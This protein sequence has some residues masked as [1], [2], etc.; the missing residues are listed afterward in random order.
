MNLHE[1]HL[2]RAATV[3]RA[4][5]ALW[6][7]PA[8]L[9]MILGCHLSTEGKGDTQISFTRIYDSLKQYDDVVIVLKNLNGDTLDVIFRGKVENLGDVQ[10][11]SAPHWDGGKVI[12]SI[13]GTKDGQIVYNVETRFDPATGVKDS[14]VVFAPVIENLSSTVNGLTLYVGESMLLPSIT[15]SQNIND[16][17]LEWTSSPLGLLNLDP[18]SIN[19]LQVGKGE[20]EVHLKSN[21]SVSLSI[22]VEVLAISVMPESISVQPESL[23]VAAGGTA[24]TLIAQVFPAGSPSG[25]NWSSEDTGI[26]KVDIAGRVQGVRNGDARV[27]AASRVRPNLHGAARIK[28]SSS[29][30]V[31]TLAFAKDSLDILAGGAAESLLVSVLPA[32]ADP[33]VTFTVSDPAKASVQNAKVTGIAAGRVSVIAA[34]VSNPAAKDTLLV[35]I[36]VPTPNDTTPPLKPIVHVTPVGPTQNL[37][38][39]W[40]W[41]SG[42]GGG[43]GSYQTSL[44]KT[45]FDATTP[46]VTDTTF[47]PAANLA[48]GSH[49]LYVRERDAAGNWSLPGSAQVVLDTT[50]PAAPK[51]VGT[52]PTS[53]LPRWT[54]S[55]GGGGGAGVYRSWLVDAS[56]PANAPE[57][58]DSA[59]ALTTATTGTTYTLFVEERD[60]AGNWSPPARLAIKYDLTKPTVTIALPQA[61][62]TFITASA[63]VAVSG[64]ATGPNTITKIEYTLDAGTPSAATLGTGGSWSIASLALANGQTTTIT[65]TATD[66][67]GN[68]GQAQLKVLRDSDVPLPPTAL[69]KPTSPTNVALSSWSWAAGGDGATGSGLNGNYQWKLN[70]GAWTA[71]TTA[72]A[73][74]VTLAEGSNTFSVEEQDKAGNWSDVLTGTVVLDTKA[75]DAVTFVGIDGTLTADDTPTWSW[76][77][78]TTNG[79]I[80]QYILKLD[81]GAEF[82]GS[83]ATSYIPVTSLSDNT[84]HTLTV[85]EKDQ[86]PGVVGAAKSFSYKIKVNPPAAPTVKSAVAGLTSGAFT[87]NPGF[88]WTSGGGGNGKFR[89]KVNTETSYRVN[90]VAQTTFSL[91]NTDADGTYTVS[92]SEQDDLGR[93]SPDGTFIIQLDRTGPIYSEVYFKGTTMPVRD[94]YV[95]NLDTVTITYKADGAE[96]ELGCKLDVSGT[97]KPCKA[98]NTDGLGNSSTIQRNVYCRKNVVFFKPVATGAMDG[99][100]WENASS[101][102]KAYMDLP[103][104]KGKD[105]WLASGDYSNQDIQISFK[106][107]NIYGGFSAADFP[108]DSNNRVKT[109][110]Y[111]GSVNIFSYTTDPV[112]TYD[113]LRF[114]KGLVVAG[115]PNNFTD[116]QSLGSF[117]ISESAIVTVTNFELNGAGLGDSYLFTGS[118]TKLTWDGGKINNNVPKDSTGFAIT[119]DLGSTLILKGAL[120]VS[121]NENSKNYG[122]QILNNGTLTIDS[123]VSFNCNDLLNKGTATCRGNQ[124]P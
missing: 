111:L 21:H 14:I 62:G 12:V 44:D 80:G 35:K 94:G 69:V 31:E 10:K 20:I 5:R 42:G 15:M 6:L 78:S 75:P 82:D 16:T 120:T 32:G 118:G 101:D 51:L 17:T 66:N 123:S 40:S 85:K 103:D 63:T 91:S 30:L 115:S 27:W 23:E 88:I 90:G 106:W 7:L 9:L 46:S 77:P 8:F 48:T 86:V 64:S 83:T 107:A 3:I 28:V 96:K 113:G 54:W 34:S 71:T 70:S 60:A 112:G 67:L 24:M 11:L 50:G 73:T 72:S 79:G 98:V 89:V 4:V 57:S 49:V 45:S 13:T 68:T 2:R 122:Y 47:T 97:V 65:V 53:A 43:A 55:S 104:A 56:F 26:V 1:T 93:W 39:V 76:T 18:K 108:V 61:S 22:P 19:A 74:G 52:S 99:S 58:S 119:V 102:L 124:L 38:P 25:V 87:N 29:I 84:T 37:K 95:T 121:G 36:T 81:A 41:S 109:N 105:L 92:V 117:S 114:S 100:S 110:T 116:C 33:T 59:Y